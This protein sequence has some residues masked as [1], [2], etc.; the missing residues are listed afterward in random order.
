MSRKIKLLNVVGARPNFMKMA[1]LIREMNKK[2]D[3]IEH[4]LIHTGQ[5]YDNDMS[6]NF[7]DQLGMPRP[8]IN[9]GVG[10]G[11]HAEQTAKIMIAFE[12]AIIEHRPDLVVV[13]GDV[14]STIACAL[15]AS[16]MGV[17]IAHVEAGLRSFDRNM[18]EE[19]NRVLTDALSDYLFTTEKSAHVN[20]Q[21][22]GIAKEKIFFVG[23]V[24]IDTLVH[25]LEKIRDWELPFR[26]V[27]ENKYAV[28]T[29]HRPSNVDQ[30]GTLA[31]IL[32][33]FCAI[34][35]KIAL[36]LAL[37]PRTLKNIELFGMSDKL[38]VIRGRGIV[39]GPIGYL[40]MLKLTKSAKFVITD[41]GG[42]QEETTYL[43]IPCITMRENTER[44]ITI[45]CG[46]NILVGKD[47][48]ALSANCDEILRGRFKTGSIP[49][50]WDGKASERIIDKLLSAKY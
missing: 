49:E 27:E 28:V 29:L 7:I 14:N 31:N 36:I 15:V 47:T 48:N 17:R 42:L 11:S 5:H 50:L 24:M 3:R 43:G 19:I 44:P 30:P 9:L 38:N 21:N 20:L 8:K 46:T 18:P 40:E 45:T 22:E 6:G 37:H 23:N 32:E 39:V 13:V 1:P 34:N 41:S 10:S 2:R 16:K 12:K 33:A 4:I 26:G 25:S 35:E